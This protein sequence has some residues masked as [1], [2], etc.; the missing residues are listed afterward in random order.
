MITDVLWLGA[1]RRIAQMVPAR[2]P[3]HAPRS[4]S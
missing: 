1:A 2:R 4:P 3:A